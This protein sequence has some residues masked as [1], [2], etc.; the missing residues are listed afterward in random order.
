[1]IPTPPLVLIIDDDPE[2]VGI[3]AAALGGTNAVITAFDGLDGY[4]LACR[5]RPAV[6][7]LDVMMPIV[8]GWTVLR[9]LRT[10]PATSHACVV[11]VTAAEPEVVRRE[12][13]KHQV[14]AVIHKPIDVP[15]LRK[16]VAQAIH[17]TG[18]AEVVSK[19]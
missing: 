10:N 3:L 2:I 8:D 6:I 16:I 18:P 15:E 17:G 14:F 7:L 19:G 9:K 11:V 12:G 5:R 1:M 4:A 13:A